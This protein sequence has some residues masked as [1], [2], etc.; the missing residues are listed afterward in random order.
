MTLTCVVAWVTALALSSTINAGAQESLRNAA[1][2]V[3]NGERV[4]LTTPSLSPTRRVG[5]Y[6]GVRNDSLLLRN[7]TVPE[8]VPLAIHDIRRFYVSEGVGK[9]SRR[10]SVG[11]GIGGMVAG[12]LLGMALG[13]VFFDNSTGCGTF[14]FTGCQEEVFGVFF[15]GVMGGAAGATIAYNVSRRP[16]ERWRSVPLE[17]R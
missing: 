13:E 4:R 5:L 7:L 3:R 12:A 14:D 8:S 17:R 1:P 9:R 2:L 15:L 16:R 10:A 11:W 6:A